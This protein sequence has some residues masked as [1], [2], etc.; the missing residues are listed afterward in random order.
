[1]STGPSRGGSPW[2]WASAAARSPE[3]TSRPCRFCDLSSAGCAAPPGNGDRPPAAQSQ[4]LAVTPPPVRHPLPMPA[5]R[6]RPPGSIP[7]DLEA[8]MSTAPGRSAA[9]P[10]PRCPVDIDLT[11]PGTF[12]AGMP[13]AAFAR[14]R[15]EAPVFW[16]PQEGAPG[17]GFWAVTR[18]ADIQEVSRQPEV[19]SSREHGALLHTG[20]QG[21][22]EESL[23]TMRMILFNMDPPAHTQQRRIV[24][25]AFTPRT[26]RGLEPR[27]RQL[28]EDIAGRAL[29][30]GEGDFVR[31][32][33]AELP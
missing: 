23:E 20:E 18:H 7:T 17:G 24:Q 32:I 30:K 13:L 29:A 27:L 31:D 26:I 2:T 15:E 22:T 21:E 3:R 5:G 33:A 9:G 8:L 14:M 28:A 11:D 1:M 25:R 4:G 19:F 16:H 12:T 10:R 6:T